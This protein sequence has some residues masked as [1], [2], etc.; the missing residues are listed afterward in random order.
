MINLLS[1][2]LHYSPEKGKVILQAKRSDGKI[3]FSVQDFGKGLDPHYK[4]KVFDKFYK[5][6]GSDSLGTSTGLGLAI[7]KDFITS[8]G[9]RIW[10][11]SEKGQGSKFSFELNATG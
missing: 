11:E 5:I 2:A 3:V 6:P 4:D 1:N 10:V 8:E 7:S 9:G